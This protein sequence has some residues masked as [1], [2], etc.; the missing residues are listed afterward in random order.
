MRERGSKGSKAEWGIP[1]PDFLIWKITL[2]GED[3]WEM[4]MV[5]WHLRHGLPYRDRAH[6][7]ATT[8]PE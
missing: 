6:G 2:Q 8:A 1:S 4:P 5:G 7:A 3:K